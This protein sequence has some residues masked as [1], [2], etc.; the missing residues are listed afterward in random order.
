MKEYGKYTFSTASYFILNG[1]RKVIHRYLGLSNTKAKIKYRKFSFV[2]QSF[3]SKYA[4]TPFTIIDFLIG[5]ALH[6]SFTK[7]IS[8]KPFRP[9][10]TYAT[11]KWPSDFIIYV[12]VDIT[13][14]FD[15]FY[16]LRFKKGSSTYLNKLSPN[17]I[18]QIIKR[19]K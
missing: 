6:D 8:Q 13:C 16:F 14:L 12:A 7:E 9:N 19:Q 17:L 11:F 18:P 3:W 4:A 2:W 1:L 10:A 5:K 15:C